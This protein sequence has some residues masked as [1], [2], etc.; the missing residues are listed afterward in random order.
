M[1]CRMYSFYVGTSNIFSA[2]S[3]T[4]LISLLVTRCACSAKGSAFLGTFAATAGRWRRV[5]SES[6][7]SVIFGIAIHY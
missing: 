1:G 6:V 5:W 4:P 7:R 3:P 2:V